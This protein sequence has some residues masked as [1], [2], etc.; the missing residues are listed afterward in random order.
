MLIIMNRYAPF[1]ILC[2]LV[3]ITNSCTKEEIIQ[4]QEQNILEILGIPEALIPH[5]IAFQSEAL[6]RG[7][8]INF[9]SSGISAELHSLNQGNV[10]GVCSTNNRGLRHITIDQKFWNRSGHYTREMIVFHEL[11]HCILSRGHKEDAFD[12]GVCQSIMRSGSGGC[13]DAYRLNT[14]EYFLDELFLREV[15]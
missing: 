8:D 5:F 14:R 7:Y 10:A 1:Y 15:L 12:N 13:F 9:L 3:L 11:G 4:P 6:S 2:S